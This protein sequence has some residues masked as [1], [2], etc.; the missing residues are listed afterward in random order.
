MCTFFIFKCFVLV[1][2]FVHWGP[3]RHTVS[4]RHE[5]ST[6]RRSPCWTASKAK[7]PRG[8]GNTDGTQRETPELFWDFISAPFHPLPSRWLSNNPSQTTPGRTGPTVSARKETARLSGVSGLSAQSE[9]ATT[10]PLGTFW[11]IW[12][13]RGVCCLLQ[14]S[15]F[16]IWSLN[17]SNIF[18]SNTVLKPNLCFCNNLS[19]KMVKPTSTF[20]MSCHCVNKG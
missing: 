7:L 2:Q 10:K 11:P 1:V 19:S 18:V 9:L 8:G 15:F 12:L 13:S 20:K 14:R 6:P 17:W 5:G 4:I 3:R 16:N